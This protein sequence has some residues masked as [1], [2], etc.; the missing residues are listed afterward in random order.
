MEERRWDRLERNS[1]QLTQEAV[2]SQQAQ[3]VLALVR[4]RD[5][6]VVLLEAAVQL[7]G[8][9]HCSSHQAEAGHN[10]HWV[11]DSH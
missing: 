4:E 1:L 3:A 9:E 6:E 8:H 10:T 5:L 7:E 2:H 11:A